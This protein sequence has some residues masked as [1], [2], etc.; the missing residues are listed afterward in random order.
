MTRHLL[1]LVWNRRRT[2]LLVVAE[3]FCSFLV[4]FGVALLLVQYANNYRQPLGYD[5]ER[6][7]VIGVSVNETSRRPEGDPGHVERFRQLLTGIDDL[8]QVEAVTA[9]FTHPYANASWESGIRF[10]GRQIDYGLNHVTDT[11]P[12]VIGLRLIAGR[13]FSREDDGAAARPV[14]VNARL[15]HDL[16]GT[17]DVVGR[18]VRRD[19]EPAFDRMT[20]EERAEVER[21]LRIVGVIEDFRQHGE[22]ST[23]MGYMFQRID[24]RDPDAGTPRTAMIKLQPGTPAAFEEA[25]VERMHAVAPDWSFDVTP[26][27]QMRREKLRMYLTPLVAIGTVAAFLLIMVALGLTGV[28]WQNVTQ[29]SREIGLRRAKGATK[30]GVY[31]Q[32]LAELAILTS[33][34]LALGLLLVAQ[35]PLLPLPRELQLVSGSVFVTAVLLSVVAI[36]ALTLCAGWYPSRLAMRVEPAEALRYE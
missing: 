25:L 28:V 27:D 3:I 20:P 33:M 7:W 36:Y 32:F 1:K 5:I 6:A 29:R 11:F 2:N 26:L 34:A 12:Q 30:T 13:W 4:L 23:P 35:G 8:P 17:A 9:G 24:L 19:R 21:D 18:T 15:A 22:Y 31:A 14:V 10:Q 16:F